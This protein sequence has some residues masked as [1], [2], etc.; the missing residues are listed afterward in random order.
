MR[1]L[2][3]QSDLFNNQLAVYRDQLIPLY[4]EKSRLTAERE[5]LRFMYLTGIKSKFQS[6]VSSING[7]IFLLNNPDLQEMF[8]FLVGLYQK[9][10]PMASMNGASVTG[11]GNPT[12]MT[13]TIAL[14]SFIGPTYKWFEPVSESYG[15][16]KPTTYFQ[17]YGSA[18]LSYNTDHWV[19]QYFFPPWQR[20]QDYDLAQEFK[21]TSPPSKGYLMAQEKYGKVHNVNANY[22]KLIELMNKQYGAQSLVSVIADAKD[23][24]YR[25]VDILLRLFQIQ[26]QI[27]SAE[28]DLVTFIN[29][30]SSYSGNPVE[31]QQILLDIRAAAE[32]ADEP[33]VTDIEV[34][35]EN[36][37][38]VIIEEPKKSKLPLVAAAAGIL[39][40]I[41]TNS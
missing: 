39:L 29:E 1:G 34:P 2:G 37:E 3:S 7:D 26:G 21:L 14:T 15:Y 12:V 22:D 40:L 8:N 38:E 9:S 11:W 20:I 27:E 41:S 6:I 23:L 33:A 35:E 4:R 10:I 18:Y 36:V 25:I 5:S 31:A 28:A 24:H 17:A 13:D 30:Y 16:D 19:N 32:A